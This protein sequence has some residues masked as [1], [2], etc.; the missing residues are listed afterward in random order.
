[1]RKL[2]AF[3]LGVLLS[4]GFLGYGMTIKQASA[5][6]MTP[7]EV[8]IGGMTA[9][10]TF[11]T[12]GAQVIGLC[13]VATETGPSS[14]ASEAGLRAGDVIKKVA[15]INVVNVT[16]LNEIL[17]KSKGRELEFVLQRGDEEIKI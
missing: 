10:F 16:E 4:F 1:M 9:G 14:P 13:E 8:Y 6:E 5:N 17:S 15:G 2:G 12:G 11:N 3:I 7:K